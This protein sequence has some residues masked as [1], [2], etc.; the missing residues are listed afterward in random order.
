MLG[1]ATESTFMGALHALMAIISTV[2][3]ACA[4]VYCDNNTASTLIMLV[5]QLDSQFLILFIQRIQLE[6]DCQAIGRCLEF[7]P[8]RGTE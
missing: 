5:L 6:I 8:N 2:F 1:Y 7:V 4:V 3:M